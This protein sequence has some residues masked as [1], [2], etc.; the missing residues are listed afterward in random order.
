M[1]KFLPMIALA[2]SLMLVGCGK[3]ADNP[4]SQG[5]SKTPASSQK[6]SS[7]KHAHTFDETKWES[8]ETQHWHPATCEH[9]DAKGSAAAHTWV[10]D[11]TRQAKAATCAAEG[12]KYLKCS[13][14]G[15]TKTEKTP[16]AAHDYEIKKTGGTAGQGTYEIRECK[17]C[18]EQVVA[19]AAMSGNIQGTNKDTTG[20]TLKFK[21]NNEY[22]EYTFTLDAAFEGAE[23]AL[24]GW[25]DY[26][27]DGSNNNDQ[28]GFFHN[29]APN[30]GVKVNDADVEIKNDQS[31][32][33]MGMTEGVN[34]NGSFN[35][36]P[37]GNT[38]TLKAGENVVRYTRLQSY[39]LNITEI[40]FI[41]AAK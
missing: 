25:V 40:L 4:S 32:E 31:Y 19:I 41:K 6:A 23:I 29:G 35:V 5:G 10:E 26:W 17:V 9:T 13:V 22:A 8:N 30:I 18:K 24:Y 2:M 1:K 37:I 21:T 33:A 38:A 20:E 28:R 7:S 16:K 27:K 36:C 3:P 12:E 14:C 34:G 39:N 15:A 11:T